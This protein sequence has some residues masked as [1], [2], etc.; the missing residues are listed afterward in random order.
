MKKKRK[1]KAVLPLKEIERQILDSSH[2]DYE[3][4]IESIAIELW[5]PDWK[6]RPEGEGETD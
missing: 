6:T 3:K 1:S 2:P 5:G 4:T